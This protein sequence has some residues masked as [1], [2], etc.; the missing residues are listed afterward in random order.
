VFAAERDALRWLGME[1]AQSPHR[2]SAE[3]R[4][5]L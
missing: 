4:A 2:P 3:S 5:A 1:P